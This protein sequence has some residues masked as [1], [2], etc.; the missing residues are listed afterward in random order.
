MVDI[1]IEYE[2]DSEDVITHFTLLVKPRYRFYEV[3]GSLDCMAITL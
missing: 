3:I 2:R 1:N